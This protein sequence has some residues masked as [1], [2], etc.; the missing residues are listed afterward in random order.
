MPPGSVLIIDDNEMNL[1]IASTILQEAGYT[2]FISD[3]ALNGIDMAQAEKPDIILMDMHLPDKDGYEAT[4]LL[5]SMPDVTHIPVIAFTASPIPEEEQKALNSGCSGIITKPIDIRHFADQIAQFISSPPLNSAEI[6][7]PLR[8]LRNLKLSKITHD[9]RTPVAAEFQA[10]ELLLS[11][12]LGPLTE[13]QQGFLQEMMQA[14]RDLNR[15]LT[16]LFEQ[17]SQREW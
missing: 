1:D 2:L 11:E 16:A 17:L 5:K 8:P 13:R 14:N 10:I 3:N 12:K 15:Q 4:R 9:L 7:P 6:V